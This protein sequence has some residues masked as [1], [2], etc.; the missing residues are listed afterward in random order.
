MP[1]V[2]YSAP[3]AVV[4]LR[5]G[6][7]PVKA[8]LAAIGA[9]VF[10]RFLWLGVGLWR[11][12]SYR[13]HSHPL[14][15][16]P[17]W[18]VEADLRVSD[19][20]TSPV[21]FGVLRP[22]VLLPGDFVELAPAVREAI[23]CHEVLHVRRK[24]WVF[25]FAEEII[26]SVFWFH[27]AIW[28]LLGEIG[29]ARE[30]TV[31]REVIEMTKSRE[32]YVDALLAIA[33]A[34]PMLDLAPAPLFLRKRHLKQRVISILKEGRMS[35][36]RLISALAAGLGMLAMACWLVT[37]TFPLAAAPQSVTD[38]PGVTVDLGGSAVLHRTP[39]I[40][41]DAARKGNVQGMVTLE[42][43]LDGSGNVTDARV[44]S[45][46]AELR[47]SALQAVLQ[48][49]F[50][51]DG[52]GATRLVHINFQTPPTPPTVT[53]YE[54]RTP[55][56]PE[57]LVNRMRAGAAS[58][59]TVRGIVTARP[60]LAGKR[61]T[62][63]QVLGL[64]EQGRSELMGHLQVHVGDLL[65]EDSMASISKSA[66]E[67]DEHINVGFRSDPDGSTVVTLT[68]P[69]ASGGEFRPAQMSPPPPGVK[70]IVVGGNV[71]SSLLINKIAPA[72]PPL[73]KQARISGV[74]HLGV[75][76][77]T[78]GF[79]KEIAVISGH[80]LMIPPTMEAV[81]QWQYTPTLLDGAP[82]EVQ[83]QVD[84]NFTLSDQ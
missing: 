58:A 40:Y 77:G 39:I 46:P 72:Y 60:S 38:G 35:K 5:P 13:R 32:S 31:D 75:I 6:I 50:A 28:W 59:E 82:C 66:R 53:P 10:F 51:N 56:T 43:I 22:V 1:A 68:A 3:I 2:A 34:K 52:A 12:R 7:S 24:D 14:H 36:T 54:V 9:G 47:R 71:Q 57:D 20:V 81:R 37:L 61:L 62:Q 17:S 45:G 16:A 44:I 41:P 15:S 23:L 70:R 4:P 55:G 63:I 84:V 42:A 33:G 27:P 8:A 78:N 74:V 79:V 26:R 49:H 25:M 21:T 83:T 18:N 19:D 11:L 30:Q 65:A 64:S 80:P 67:Y 73:A 69:G 29:L 76:I 48:W